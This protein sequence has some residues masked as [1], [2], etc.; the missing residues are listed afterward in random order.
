MKRSLFSEKTAKK[1]IIGGAIGFTVCSVIS[2]ITLFSVYGK[3]GS[4]GLGNNCTG[5]CINLTWQ[6]VI[7]HAALILSYLALA[8]MLAG[9]LIKIA[10]SRDKKS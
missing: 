1:L 3:A 2:L 9:A 6:T 4:N 7:G 10:A 5:S 8:V